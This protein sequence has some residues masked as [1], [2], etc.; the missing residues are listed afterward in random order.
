MSLPGFRSKT[1]VSREHFDG[2]KWD[3]DH[4]GYSRSEWLVVRRFTGRAKSRRL[5]RIPL[6][7]KVR[8]GGHDNCRTNLERAVLERVFLVE[9]DNGFQRP[10]QPVHGAWDRV[11]ALIPPLLQM[12]K[13]AKPIQRR[14]FPYLYD[15][16]RKRNLYLRAVESL[17]RAPLTIR[18]S[19]VEGFNKWEKTNFTEKPDPA[20]RVI[21]PRDPRYNVEV[22]VYLKP[23]E[24][25]VYHAIDQLFERRP[26]ASSG[27]HKRT[28]AKG[29][30]FARRGRILSEK[31]KRFRRPRGLLFDAKRFDQHCSVQALL[32]EFQVYLGMFSPS[33]GR[34]LEMLLR[35]QLRTHFVGRTDDGVVKFEKRGGRCSGDMNTALGNVILMCLM[36]F[37][38]LDTLGI[39]YE[40]YDDGD[41]SVLIVELEDVQTVLDTYFQ[42]FLDL[43]YTMKLG[44]VAT[45]MEEIEFCQTHP[46]YDGVRWTM[47]RNPHVALA[48]DCISTLPCDNPKV[49]Q[50]WLAAVADC[51]EAIAGKIPIWDAF[52]RA[53]R[54]LSKGRKALRLPE[55]LDSG[56]YWT[57]KGMRR[58]FGAISDEARL[59]FWRAFG[60]Q[61]SFQMAIEQWLDGWQDLDFQVEELRTRP[62][63][64]SYDKLCL[65]PWP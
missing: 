4:F 43:G 31:W 62:Q 65:M 30:N 41:D 29:H 11:R 57:S 55:I 28:V 54:R 38:Y 9:G 18:D 35:W 64:P 47:I 51:G 53:Y 48:K 34:R 39:D 19:Y 33:V 16:P 24:H 44:R 52:Y 59:S 32:T 12:T 40:L 22:G 17:E 3:L 14:E 21:Q 45:C 37:A 23:I 49:V 15:E 50:G 61:P 25:D 5:Y 46:I 56:M 13:R 8:Y 26:N 60:L 36:F 63:H 58:R 27:A 20:P 6:G 42:F 10:P 1:K 7:P 2:K